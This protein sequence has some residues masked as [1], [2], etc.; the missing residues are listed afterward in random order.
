MMHSTPL[1]SDSIWEKAKLATYSYYERST[2]LP[3]VR[4]CLELFE[5]TNKMKYLTD[6]NDFIFESSVEDFC[7]LSDADVVVSTIHKAKGREFDDVYMLITDQKWKDD[8]LMRRFYVGMTRAK[9][10]LFI[11]T[12]SPCF[13]N[14]SAA[15]YINCSERY[16]MP[17]EIVLQL[18]HRDVFLDYFKERKKEVLAL[19]PGDSLNYNDY[20]LYSGATN[21]PVAKLSSSMQTAIR[22]WMDRGYSVKSA[23]VRFIVAWKPKNVA[24]DESETA[25]IL[26]DLVLSHTPTIA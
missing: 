2:A 12:N 10:R 15:Q 14:I 9:N 13:D 18:S 5:Q 25:V 19:Q 26:A 7:D 21:K 6:F 24:K 23:S 3:Y 4:R 17:D 20:I 1:I 16:S 11:H 8:A 22:E